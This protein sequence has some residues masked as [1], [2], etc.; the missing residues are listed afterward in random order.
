MEF[1]LSVII[2]TYNRKKLVATAIDSVKEFCS[3]SN[4]TGEIIIVDD[5]S[6]DNTFD[7]VQNEY[8]REI[9]AGNVKVLRNRQNLG[10]TGARNIGAGIANGK[11]LV[12][13]DSDDALV[14]ENSRDVV[15]V[16]NTN[17]TAPLIFF[18]CEDF[19]SGQLIGPAEGEA[20]NL[21][22]KKFLNIGTPGE[23]LPFVSS[24]VFQTHNFHEELRGCE[25]LTYARII[26]HYGDAIVAPLIARRYRT[27]NSDR[28]SLGKGFADR[29]C[30]IC[31][32]HAIILKDFYRYLTP[33][34]SAKTALKLIYYGL[35]CGLQ[36]I[37]RAQ[38]G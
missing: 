2:P 31:R 29:A 9:G 19:E 12:F 22:L 34:N 15:N 36:R 37:K 13:L 20:F 28:L 14:P 32:Y 27:I 16:L 1:F 8:A 35:R 7:L 18:R 6:T 5:A 25:G 21:D 11:W 24:D 38:A 30:Y 17:P 26:S 3:K 23:C 4:C 10:V 33:V